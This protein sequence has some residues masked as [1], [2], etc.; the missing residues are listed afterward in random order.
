MADN[1]VIKDGDGHSQTFAAKDVAGIKIPRSVPT[2][3][4]GTTIAVATSTKQDAQST[5]IGAVTETTPGSD[6]G[7]SGLN[8]RLQRIAQR[9]TSLIALIPAA[10][11]QTTKSGS[12]AVTVASDDDLQGKLGALTETA[13]ASDTASSGLNGRLQRVA[14][15]LTSL[16][17]LLPTSLGA[18]A[19]SASLAVTQSTEDAAQLGSLTETAPGTDTASSGLN[20]RLQRIAQRITSLIALVP[21]ALT[22]SGNFKVAINE[23]IAAGTAVIGGMFGSTSAASGGV[24]SIARLV[25][26][27]SGTNGAFAKSSAGRAYFAF[28]HNAAA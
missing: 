3:E 5:L 9:L 13:P 17:A 7:S 14:Q 19:A 22:G 21:A 24:A 6:T 20:G 26:A 4:D 15:R 11:G 18:K 28:G 2:A 10:L 23:A 1:Y 8:G 27:A 25:S 16:I 12:F